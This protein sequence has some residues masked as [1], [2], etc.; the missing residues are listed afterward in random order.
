MLDGMI[1]L[2]GDITSESEK[3]RKKNGCIRYPIKILNQKTHQ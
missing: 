1:K 3:K 2:D